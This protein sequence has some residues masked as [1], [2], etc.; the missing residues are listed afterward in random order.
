MAA[1][2]AGLYLGRCGRLAGGNSSARAPGKGDEHRPYALASP[3]HCSGTAWKGIGGIMSIARVPILC[4][5]S[6][7]SDGKGKKRRKESPNLC[8]PLIPFGLT[9]LDLR[10]CAELDRVKR[11]PVVC[12]QLLP[13]TPSFSSLT[14]PFESA[15]ISSC[16]TRTIVSDHGGPLLLL[17]DYILAQVC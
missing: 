7:G 2:W 10:S 8:G 4:T 6:V 11:H 3:T 5:V 9:A 12:L 16:V 14:I 13:S 1:R 17:P 15:V